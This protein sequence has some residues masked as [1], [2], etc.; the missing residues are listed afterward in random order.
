V[1]KTL[2]K[3]LKENPSADEV[4]TMMS[5]IETDGPRGATLLAASII[6]DILRGALRYRFIPLSNDE[7]EELF[8]GTSPLATFSARIRVLYALGVIGKQTRHDLNK[9]RELRNAMAHAKRSINFDTPEIATIIKSFHS[10]KDVPGYKT[11]SNRDLFVG[12]VM[13]LMRYMITKVGPYPKGV[14]GLK[15]IG[16]T[17]LD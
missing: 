14:K 5:E 3:L 17:Q 6:D 9:L 13:H 7:Q 10:A 2:K 15:L 4:K 12:C 1:T 8:E 16:N 11:K